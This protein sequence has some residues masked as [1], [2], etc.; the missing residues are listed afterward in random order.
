L[1]LLLRVV[2]LN[3]RAVVSDFNVSPQGLNNQKEG[4]MEKE[5]ARVEFTFAD[6][7]T[8]AL[9]GAELTAWVTLC[10]AMSDYLLPGDEHHQLGKGFNG[11]VA[12]FVPPEAFDRN[13]NWQPL[14]EVKREAQ[15]AHKKS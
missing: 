7:A 4:T 15:H 5:I 14:M 10:V 6:G 12:G 1:A 13:G 2:A 3:F 8:R 11:L 9:Q